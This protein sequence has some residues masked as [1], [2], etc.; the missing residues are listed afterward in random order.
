[1]SRTMIGSILI[2]TGLALLIFAL[3]IIILLRN[4]RLFQR[5]MLMAEWYGA[6]GLPAGELVYE[7]ADGQGVLL[8]SDQYPL[9]GKPDYVVKLDDQRLVPVELK[10]STHNATTPYSNHV[11]QLAAYCLILEDYAERP[12]THGILRYADREFTIDYTPTLRR[13]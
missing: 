10:L 13:K 12:P 6:L 2:P 5:S 7:D 1:M 3:A 4:E 9:A 11:L 8:F